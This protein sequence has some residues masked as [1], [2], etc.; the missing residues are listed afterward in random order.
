MGI[1]DIY[2]GE[3]PKYMGAGDIYLG[4]I[5]KYIGAGDIYGQREMIYTIDITNANVTRGNPS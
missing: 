2:L 3:I 4:E 1:G 5:P